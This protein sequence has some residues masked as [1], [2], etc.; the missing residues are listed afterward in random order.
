M[1]SWCRMII[2]F[3]PA[4]IK[5]FHFIYFL[6]MAVCLYKV[7]QANPDLN[8][9]FISHSICFLYLIFSPFL[10]QTLAGQKLV[11]VWICC[12]AGSEEQT[13]LCECLC[14][15]LF[16]SEHWCLPETKTTIKAW[17]NVTFY[18]CQCWM[19]WLAYIVDET[20]PVP[21][22]DHPHRPHFTLSIQGET[23]TPAWNSLWV[24]SFSNSHCTPGME[25]GGECVRVEEYKY[26]EDVAG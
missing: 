14:I 15:D 9:R 10:L 24:D 7:T 1:N 3:T 17:K 11:C 5:K 13:S 16:L 25:I 4:T 21:G 2:N 20:R 6:F 8:L 19:Q 23:L 26:D 18:L 12:P 22:L